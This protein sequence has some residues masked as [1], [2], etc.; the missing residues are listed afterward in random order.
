MTTPKAQSI[1]EHNK[2]N[3][4]NFFQILSKFQDLCALDL[5]QVREIKRVKEH[6]SQLLRH[7]VPLT[8][9]QEKARAPG[10]A[11]FPG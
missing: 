7:R 9:F 10:A 4:I 8:S 5:E 1:K 3:I 11:H 2:L 6:S